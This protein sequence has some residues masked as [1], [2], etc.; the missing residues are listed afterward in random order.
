MTE[1]TKARFHE[2][3]KAHT[4]TFH[5]LFDP[6][7]V[8]F[9]TWL[10]E[11]TGSSSPIYWI[12]GKPGSGKS[13]LMKFAID[14]ARTWEI[15]KSSPGPDWT[16]ASFF[17]HDRGSAIQKSLL[18]MLQEVTGSLL[19]QLPEL[20]FCVQPEYIKLATTQKSSRPKWDIDSLKSALFNMVE[21]RKIRLRLI[22]FLDA[23]DEHAGDNDELAHILKE[24]IQKVDND[25]VVVKVCLASRSW[26]VFEHHLRG[27][28]GLTIH[29]HT[30]SDVYTY[31]KD[32]LQ[33]S[34]DGFPDL[35]NPRSLEALTKQITTKA[36]GVFI[37]VRLVLDRL[38]KAVQDGTPYDMLVEAVAQMPQELKKLY[39]DIL[40]RLGTCLYYHFV[41]IIPESCKVPILRILLVVLRPTTSQRLC[42]LQATTSVA[43]GHSPDLAI[44][45]DKRQLVI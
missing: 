3:R 36:L 15:L 33:A 21:Q 1:V 44:V 26:N 29:E 38:V 27:Y 5:W 34:I 13:T 28:L 14:D 22:F 2:V 6:D 43:L 18:G 10:R 23:L 16:C 31:T 37:W 17:F 40:R 24:T 9:S 11:D 4:R 20:L 12:K 42:V 45:H 30:E 41:C 35:L 32:R 8:S 19:Y 25:R 39:A 7:T